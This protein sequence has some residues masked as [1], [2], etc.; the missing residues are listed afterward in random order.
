MVGGKNNLILRR[1]IIFLWKDKVMQCHQRQLY[2]LTG[3]PCSQCSCN[4]RY[5]CTIWKHEQNY[6]R[7]QAVVVRQFLALDTV[8]PQL[9]TGCS[10]QVL[11]KP[12]LV[13]RALLME[14]PQYTGQVSGHDSPASSATESHVVLHGQQQNRW[15]H[16]AAMDLAY[17]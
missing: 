13:Q 11:L 16:E 6:Y 1:N 4:P 17:F 15:A 9:W 10:W 3:S 7:S 5:L 14:L 12:E 8:L 2:A